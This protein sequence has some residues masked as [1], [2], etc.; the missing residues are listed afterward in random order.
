MSIRA[1]VRKLT[2]QWEALGAAECQAKYGA[3]LRGISDERLE[4][5]CRRQDALRA[6]TRNPEA[7]FT[8]AQTAEALGLTVAEL[9]EEIERAWC[10]SLSVQKGPL[11]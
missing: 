3:W 4:T 1:R 10:E 9:A 2:E 8:D 7:T 5:L 11:V 6:D